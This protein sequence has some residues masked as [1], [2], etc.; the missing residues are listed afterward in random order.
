LGK[1]R[2][3]GGAVSGAG[4]RRRR[5]LGGGGARGA[6]GLPDGSSDSS[7]GGRIWWGHAERRPAVALL[8]GGDALV[9]FGR[10]GRALEL[11]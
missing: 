3:D 5:G 7:W 6:Q 2:R 8:A 10:G 11:Q 1:Q 4:D 9:V